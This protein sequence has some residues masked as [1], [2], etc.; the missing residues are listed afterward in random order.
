M[1]ATP[2]VIG[3]SKLLAQQQQLSVSQV[4]NSGVDFGYGQ[5]VDTNAWPDTF[6]PGN[7]RCTLVRVGAVG[8]SPKSGWKWTAANTKIGHN[9]GV[10][11]T[12][13]IVVYKDKTC[14]VFA[15]STTKNDTQFIY[16][17][18]TDDTANTT[19]LIF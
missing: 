15:S 6:L 16:L 4:L 11:P 3:Q 19:L 14:D 1:Q 7:I 2:P 9:L 10:L 12:G 17:T 18:I 8:S 13:F 5:T